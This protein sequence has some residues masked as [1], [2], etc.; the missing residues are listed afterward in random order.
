MDRSMLCLMNLGHGEV[1]APGIIA[2]LNV[3]ETYR[4]I[5]FDEQGNTGRLTYVRY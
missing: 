5:D 1:C 4:G 3:R 2:A